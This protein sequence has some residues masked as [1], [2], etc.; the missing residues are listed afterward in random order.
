MTRHQKLFA[1]IPAAGH[2]QRMGQPKLLLPLGEQTVI[3]R[4]L[5]VLNRAD[6]DERLVVLRRDDASLRAEVEAA[7][8]RVVAPELPPPDMRASV[9]QALAEI[10]MSH[11]PA[12]HDGWLL[13]PADHP[14]LSASVLEQLIAAWNQ[15][16]ADALVPTFQGRRGHPTFFRWRLADK[17]SAIPSGRGLNQLLN[18][19]SVQVQEVAVEDRSVVVDL[20]TPQDYETLR[21]QYRDGHNQPS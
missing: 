10:R 14:L 9:E 2:S 7:G 12:A 20:D 16:D 3:R 11:R 17:I 19:Q 18:T 6:V 13:I 15:S 5:D 4:L 21:Q 1:V 8:A